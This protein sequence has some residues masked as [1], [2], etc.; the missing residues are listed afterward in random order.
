MKVILYMAISANGMIAGKNDDTSWV[1]KEDFEGQEK[2]AKMVGNIV[3][4][5]RTFERGLIEG[6]LPVTGC[7]NVVAT[8]DPNRY[9]TKEGFLFIAGTP[10]NI[11]K[12]LKNK[13][14]NKVLVAGGSKL[15]GSFIK[16]GLIDEMYLDVEPI[17]FGEGIPLFAPADF[18]YKLKPLGTKKLSEQTLQLHYK[19]LK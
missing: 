9:K 16:E 18:E 17:I 8:S 5:S 15:N 14:F 19:V 3:Y 11:L 10:Q 12:I 7:V 6:G 13:G 2:V 1:S 4:G